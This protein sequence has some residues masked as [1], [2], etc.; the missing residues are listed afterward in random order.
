MKFTRREALKSIGGAVAGGAALHPLLAGAD[1]DASTPHIATNTYPW[2]TFAKRAGRPFE[3]SDA[4]LAEIAKTGIAGYEPIVH[5]PGE[6]KGLGPRLR[7]QGLEMR[8]LYV[9]SLLHDTSKSEESIAH[10]VAIA[11]VAR[12]LGT[13]IV[14]VNPTPIR[15]GGDEDKS[16][17]E[18]RTQ[19]ASLDRLGG[20]LRE[21]G[22]TLAY[23][24]HDA[25]LRQGAR[26]FHHM[27]TATNPEN[28]KLCLDSH[29]IFRG[30]GNSSVAVFDALAHYHSRVVELHLR[31]ST[32]GV[33]TEAFAMEGDID[34]G[35][36]FKYLTARGRSPHFVL[37][38]AV[39][40]SSPKELTATEAHRK[41]R[42]ALA[43]AL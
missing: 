13:R 11:R 7:K 26:E 32:G 21:L 8:S 9:N 42:A 2:L 20:K 24:N 15:W 33:W 35:R 14:V 22:V 38:Q 6:L 43:S 23:H 39:E 3:Q 27:L 10:V 4:L 30:C 31:Q 40:D 41:G 16:D 36:L 34:Y 37:E 28:V 12:K 17:P 1:S 19:A 29:W 25:E 18:L 5:G